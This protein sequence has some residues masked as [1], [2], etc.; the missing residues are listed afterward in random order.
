MIRHSIFIFLLLSNIT[1]CFGAIPASRFWFPLNGSLND[2]SGH[3]S[4]ATLT[5]STTG[6]GY[7]TDVTYGTVYQQN[8][9]N[10]GAFGGLTTNVLLP[11]VFSLSCWVDVLE[12]DL[13]TDGSVNTVQQTPQYVF[14]SAL[15]DLNDTTFPVMVVYPASYIIVDSSNF[16]NYPFLNFI[17]A[18]ATTWIHIVATFD[19]TGNFVLYTNGVVTGTPDQISSTSLVIWNNNPK[20]NITIGFNSVTSTIPNN[21]FGR[22]RDAMLFTSALTDAEVLELYNSQYIAPP[23][24]GSSSSNNLALIL[25]TTIGG[26]V[27]LAGVGIG[28]YFLVQKY[29]PKK[30]VKRTSSGKPVPRAK[31]LQMSGRL[32]NPKSK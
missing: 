10:T 19:S 7:V 28:T 15:S 2:V 23:A 9:R 30:P 32:K 16:G 20:P 12:F 8:S 26:A 4:Q 11:L 18:V 6:Y 17:P 3:S 29:P 27:F 31:S 21:V 1:L 13:N 25:G 5:G 14:G 22:M 24:S